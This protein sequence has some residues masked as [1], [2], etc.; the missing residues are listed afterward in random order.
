MGKNENVSYFYNGFI[1]YRHK[2]RDRKWAKTLFE[3]LENFRSPKALIKTG[4]SPRISRIFRDE[5][6]L[7]T[8][9]NLSDDI[10]R[11]LE[12][13]RTLIVVCS[14]DTPFSL[15]VCR[16]IEAFIE[17]GR[18]NRI[19]AIVIDDDPDMSLPE[20]LK[21]FFGKD[22]EK[23]EY[24]GH[25]IRLKTGKLNYPA[26]IPV[27]AEALGVKSD[28]LSEA[29][30]KTAVRKRKITAAIMTSAI[31]VIA[32]IFYLIYDYIG[33]KT[34]YYRSFADRYSLPAGIGMID[35]KKNNQ[36]G[37]M[38]RFEIRM[39]KLFRVVMV[40]SQ[41]EK[42]DDDWGISER[43]ISYTS[44]K[45]Q[46]TLKNSRGVVLQIRDYTGDRL[47]V[48]LTSGNGY[49]IFRGWESPSSHLCSFTPRNKLIPSY[50]NIEYD[51]NGFIR[52]EMY[53]H[54][55]WNTPAFDE[56]SNSGKLFEYNRNGLVTEWR[57]LDSSGDLMQTGPKA[58]GEKLSY[59]PDGRELSRAFIN[60]R[61]E[62][63]NGPGK[64]YAQVR[65]IYEVNG[66][67]LTNYFDSNNDPLPGNQ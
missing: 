35:F 60:G 39:G 36:A 2:E 7:P 6:E 5:N 33:L 31:A 30:I 38:Y 50:I 21:I 20:P 64:P 43:D 32:V 17:M 62:I 49:E 23:E 9:P 1:S 59:G 48:E 42:K 54:D 8:S 45:I 46:I 25:M 63:V 10:N 37:S 18:G 24:H 11:A 16:E 51:E 15:W 40:D 57:G 61:G 41:G 47:Q 44:G 58:G 34:L 26:F 12:A 4:T 56:C 65:F 19:F 28:L 3:A 14:K 27:I 53:F 67:I 66:S 52:K 13:S 22:G 55:Q 29:I